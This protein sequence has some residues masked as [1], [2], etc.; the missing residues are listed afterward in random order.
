MV[1]AVSFLARCRTW[2]VLGR[3]AV[4]ATLCLAKAVDHDRGVD[5][6][7]LHDAL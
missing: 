1:A 3:A 4:T 6:R 2:G 7:A 5:H